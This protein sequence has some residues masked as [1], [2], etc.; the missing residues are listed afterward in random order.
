MSDTKVV[1][2]KLQDGTTQDVTV[3]TTPPQKGVAADGTEMVCYLYE[4]KIICFQP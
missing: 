2:V 3:P 1:K 4:G